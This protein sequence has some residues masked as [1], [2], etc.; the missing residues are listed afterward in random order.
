MKVLN[1]SILL[2][3][4]LSGCV[5]AVQ[6]PV[7]L[8]SEPFLVIAHR[9]A[10]AY[11]PAHTFPSYEL[12]IEMG[13]HYIELDLHRTKDGKLV[14]L[15]NDSIELN[16]HE[17]EID[18]I[19]S[20]V[21]S[22]FKPAEEFNQPTNEYASQKF[23]SLR[24]PSL[25]QVL[26]EFGDQTNYYIEI[27]SPDRY[28]GIERQLIDQLSDHHLLD[29]D[30][31]LPKVIIQSFSSD[32]LK[33]VHA[34]SPGTPLI[35]LYSFK[36]KAKLSPAKLKKVS[37]YASGIGVNASVVT[38]HLVNTVHESG[39]AIHPFTV[40]EIE[41]LSSLISM[42]IDGVFTDKPD[43]IITSLNQHKSLN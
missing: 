43:L 31:P 19:S 34:L 33:E 42:G 7:P 25:E 26:R 17:V 16:G 5:P 4:F 12:A 13:A 40:N 35:Q 32:S 21:L 2:I 11:A 38:E 14:V 20:D 1:V 37:R 18:E 8:P 23:A 6:Q 28:P 41:Q 27:K 36:K 30:D 3:L 39:L 29:R 15:H 22:A 9:G 24:V 10:S